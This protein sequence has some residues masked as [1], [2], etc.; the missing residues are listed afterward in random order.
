VRPVLLIAALLSPAASVD[1]RELPPTPAASEADVVVLISADTEWRAVKKLL[2]NVAVS[3]SPY[4]EQFLRTVEAGTKRPVLFFH[5]GWGKIAAAGSTQYAID[6]FRP[7][8]L[9]NLGTCGGF[10]GAIDKGDV[11]LVEKTVVYDIVEQMGDPAEAIAAYTTTVDLHRADDK[12]P[13]G[14]RRGPLVSADRDIIPADIPRLQKQYGA[15]AADWESGAIAWVAERNHVPVLILR[16]VTDLVG[17]EGGEA[18][19]NPTVFEEG[20]AVVMKRLLDLLPYWL[21]RF[22][23]ASARRP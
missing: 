12:L 13:P 18:Y 15:L 21:Q 16:G 1:A 23:Q 5:G 10:Q 2:P 19:G 7:R 6:R 17:P 11:L 3:A 20:T 9:V 22:N 4:G 14:V 8:L